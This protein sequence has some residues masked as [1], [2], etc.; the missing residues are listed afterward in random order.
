MQAGLDLSRA[1][2]FFP[3]FSRATLVAVPLVGLVAVN[4]AIAAATRS[5]RNTLVA[6]AITTALAVFLVLDAVGFVEG[7]NGLGNGAD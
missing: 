5:M 2:L 1:R 7:L 4:L 3:G 6:V